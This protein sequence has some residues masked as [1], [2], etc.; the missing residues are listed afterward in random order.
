MKGRPRSL[1][2]WAGARGGMPVKLYVCG[3]EGGR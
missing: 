1:R 2:A 3:K